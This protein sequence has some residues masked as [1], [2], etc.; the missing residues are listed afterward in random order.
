MAVYFGVYSSAKSFL[1]NLPSY[2]EE[3]KFLAVALAASIG[4]TVASVLRVPYE[5]IKQ[6]MQN[7]E[8]TS[9][10][11][12]IAHSWKNEGALGLF[13]N[14][15]LYSQIIRDIPYA[16]VTLCTYEIVQSY[17]KEKKTA[18]AAATKEDKKKQKK[19]KSKNNCASD[20]DSANAKKGK[21][22]GD[23]IAGAIAGGFGSIATT[24]MDVVKTRMMVNMG[25]GESYVIKDD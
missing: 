16:I 17:M 15:K 23:A 1:F 11:E 3:Y 9:T 20:S 7:G 22:A 5:V 14:G 4:N 6:R 12:A 8:F 21:S 2:R 19:E 25:N 24:P 18:A 13:A 10:M